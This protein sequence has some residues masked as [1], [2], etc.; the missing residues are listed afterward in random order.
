[1]K[2]EVFLKTGNDISYGI[3]DGKGI[4]V[5][6][7]SILSNKTK[8]SY[9]HSELRKELINEYTEERGG[10]LVVK[11]SISFKSPSAASNFCTGSSS[12]GLLLWKTEDGIT[13]SSYL[14]YMED[15]E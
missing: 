12:N 3:F 1:M 4:Q 5:L 14:R 8:P 9:K 10:K 7:G 13:L 6:P 11:K 15:E 2:L